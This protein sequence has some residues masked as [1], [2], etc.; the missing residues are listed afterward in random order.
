MALTEDDLQE[1]RDTAADLQR[2]II[3][4]RES[5]SNLVLE[6]AREADAA[7]LD[8]E[9]ERLQRELEFERSLTETQLNDGVLVNQEPEPYNAGAGEA[10]GDQVPPASLDTKSPETPDLPPT[11]DVP[12]PPDVTPATT[13]KSAKG[14]TT[15][16]NS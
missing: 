6:K 9:I 5:R 11:P 14:T 15:K 10:A 4:E 16:E 2:Q 8:N 13:E 12:A 7:I 3:E 1:K